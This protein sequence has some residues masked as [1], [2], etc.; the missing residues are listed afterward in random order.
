MTATKHN[1]NDAIERT[2]SMQI[3]GNVCYFGLPAY[4]ILRQIFRYIRYFDAKS[5]AKSQQTDEFSTH[6]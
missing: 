2:R 1:N 4:G 3:V 6:L 5:G